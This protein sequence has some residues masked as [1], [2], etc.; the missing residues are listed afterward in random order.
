MTSSR[1]TASGVKLAK[2]PG[3]SE[4]FMKSHD[5]LVVAVSTVISV[6]ASSLSSN[7]PPVLDARLTQQFDRFSMR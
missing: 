1:Y 3:E 5:D 2:L 6:T 4:V 7:K